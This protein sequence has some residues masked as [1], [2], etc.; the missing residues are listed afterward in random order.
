MGIA[1]AKCLGGANLKGATSTRPETPARVARHPLFE[2]WR[3]DLSP[4]E[5]E[6]VNEVFI[7]IGG[8]QGEERL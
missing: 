3:P 2:I 1:L 8:Q 5:C 7:A 6:L 4:L